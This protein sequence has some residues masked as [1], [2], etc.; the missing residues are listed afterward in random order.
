MTDSRAWAAPV[1]L[2]GQGVVLRE[3]TTA[4]LPVLIELL[5][6]PAVARYTPMPSPFDAEAAIAHLARARERREA[7]RAI[8]LAITTDGGAAK[9]EVLLFR[10]DDAPETAE[11]GYAIGAAH[12]GLGLAAAALRRLT[13]HAWSLG[14][15]ALRLRIEPGNAASEATARAAGYRPTGAPRRDTNKGRAITLRTWRHP[16]GE[17]SQPFV[18]RSRK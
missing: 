17:P 4:D 7:G 3:W 9:G 8:Q 5:D 10:V 1:R 16:G 12:R 11:L 14:L 6:D 18:A 15:D 2:D 13:A